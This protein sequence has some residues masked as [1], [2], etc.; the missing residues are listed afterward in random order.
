MG[1]SPVCPTEK[2]YR[3]SHRAAVHDAILHDASY[4]SLVEVKGAEQ[5]LVSMLERFC[6]PQGPGPSSK[7][8]L[9]GSRVLETWMYK[10]GSYPYD[11]IA[12]VTVVWKPADSP[13][14][15]TAEPDQINAKGKGKAKEPPSVPAENAPSERIRCVWLRFHPS[16]HTEVLNILQG[17]ASQTLATYKEVHGDS[18]EM[19][20]EIANLKNHVNV[21]EIIGPKSS[22]VIRG[23]LSPVHSD[24]RGDFLKFWSSLT[25]LQS[26]GSVPRGM[27]I[28]FT[29]NDPRLSFPPKNAKA[30]LAPDQSNI[31]FPSV[32][33]AASDVWDERVRSGLAKPRYR[34]KDLDER[35]SNNGIPG[36]R[37]DPLRQ[38]DRI[39]VL[40]IQRSLETRDSNDSQSLHGW[41][42]IVPKGWSMAFFSSL[43]F[44][45]T[46]VGG[47]RERQTQSYE[48]GTPYFPRDYPPSQPYQEWIE[49]QEAKEKLKWDRKPPAKRV[50][51][52]KLGVKN[53]WRPDWDGLLRT[54][55]S[56]PATS[57]VTTQRETT[58]TGAAESDKN[59][60]RWLLRGSEVPKILSAVSSVL[61]PGGALLSE[62]NRLRSKRHHPILPT[63]IKAVDLLEGALINVK[64]DMCSRGSPE[65]LCMIY[66]FTDDLARQWSK[67]LHARQ[68]AGVSIDEDSPQEAELSTKVP[69]QDAVIGYVTTGRFSL[70]RGHGFGIGAISL[71]HLLELEH[72]HLRLYPNQK[73]QSK[74]PPLLVGIQNTN[75]LQCRPAHIEVIVDA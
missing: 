42:L 65:S 8:C 66:S 43:V 67:T 68:S 64:I 60:R 54:P 25:N 19:T 7:R 51:Y 15:T 62:I 40:L 49:G 57:F 18:K 70:S 33:L 37:L 53:P 20:L 36:T 58:D 5:I 13:T 59:V 16:V 26:A 10:P 48:A 32:R 45:T 34:K 52:E 23:A 41:T 35:R 9:G 75:S 1:L 12:P 46:R 38:D 69:A 47:Q 74:I 27:I 30:K 11:L 63:D 22:Q 72:Q 73:M 39:P 31:V 29:V 50:N 71:A 44:T 2:A 61:N 28:G 17:A 14:A 56:R 21:F 4:Y 55:G 6:D 24:K 3:P